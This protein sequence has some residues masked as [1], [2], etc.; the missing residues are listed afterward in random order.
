MC[1]TNWQTQG[2]SEQRWLS[3]L[4]VSQPASRQV[5]SLSAIPQYCRKCV[6]RPTSS[7]RSPSAASGLFLFPLQTWSAGFNISPVSN[8]IRV[9]LGAQVSLGVTPFFFSLF[10]TAKLNCINQRRG[11]CNFF[12]T[13]YSVHR[14]IKAGKTT[15]LIWVQPSTHA[16]DPSRHL[17]Q[18]SAFSWTPPGVVTPAPIW[19]A[20]S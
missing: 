8:C 17:V 18:H 2:H 20:C 5:H 19:A 3:V 15:E 11:I 9:K 14:I 12:F 4:Q 6:A 13:V 1:R 7:S 16:C 10:L